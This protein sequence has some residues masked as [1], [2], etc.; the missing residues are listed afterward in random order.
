M[1]KP[2]S[3]GMPFTLPPRPSTTWRSER[4][5]MSM[6]R[7]HVTVDGS[8]PSSLPCSRLASIIAASRLFAAVIAWMSPV[9]W[10]FRSSIGTTWA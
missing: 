1:S 10:R 8:M 7:R 4:S 5:F 3:R 6:Q 2:D 9:K